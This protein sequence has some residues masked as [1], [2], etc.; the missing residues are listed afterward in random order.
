[1]Y[2]DDLI[3]IDSRILLR[4]IYLSYIVGCK[5]DSIKRFSFDKFKNNLLIVK[6]D[7]RIYGNGYFEYIYGNEET[8]E[9]LLRPFIDCEI[10][11]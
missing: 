7:L 8:A 4:D 6:P 11:P 10:K 3:I 5:S 1:M 2:I 9:E